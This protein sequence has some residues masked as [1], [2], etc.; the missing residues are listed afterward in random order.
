[1]QPGGYKALDSL[2]LEKGYRYYSMDVT[3]TENP[4]AAGLGFCVRMNKG[5]FVGR[6]ALLRIQEQGIPNK[7]CTLT[8]GGEDYR[9]IYGGEA[10]M[11]GKQVVGRLRSAG[12]G[13]TL[14][15]N[16]AYA[17]LPKALSHI[18]VKLAVDVFGELA[19]AE[20][21][22]DVLYDPDGE[23]PRG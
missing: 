23:R 2:R 17:Y 1:L 8:V 12:Y 15:R 21:A 6:A 13:Y 7:L 20:V 9:T 22:P 10:V 5:D 4:F 19:P 3:K 18:G 16:I 14:A 11:D